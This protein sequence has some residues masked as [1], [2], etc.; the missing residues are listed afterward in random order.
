M[1]PLSRSSPKPKAL[2]KRVELLGWWVNYHRG[3]TY[4]AILKDRIIQLGPQAG[5]PERWLKRIL[6]H[7]ISEFSKKG[8]GP[9]YYGYH[10][11]DHELEAAYFTLIAATGLRPGRVAFTQED[12]NYLFVAALFHD[13]DPQKQ[14]DK[15]HEDSVERIVRNDPKIVQFIEELGLNIDLVIAV[16][17]RTAYPFLGAI[18]EHAE[19][20]MKEL[21]DAAGLAEDDLAARTRFTNLGWFLSVAERIAGYALG[22]FQHSMDLARKNAHAL[23]WHPSVINERSVQ[24]FSSL[25]S[26][27]EMFENVMAGIPEGYRRTFYSNAQ[28]F[29]EAWIEEQELKALL[30]D[31]VKMTAVVE[32]N[33]ISLGPDTDY[34]ADDVRDAVTKIYEGQALPI[35]VSEDDFRRALSEQDTILVTLRMFNDDGSA[36]IVGYAKG[37]PLEKSKLRRG[38]ADENLGKRNTAYL[39][40]IGIM[41]GFWGSSGGHLLRLRFF[42]EASKRG[43]AFVTGYAHRE[44]ILQRAKKGEKMEIVQRYDPDML[45][46][47]RADLADSLYQTILNDSESIYVGQR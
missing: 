31:R 19:S 40:G 32:G 16:I 44:V 38:T 6:R 46:Y 4:E 20:R 8:L 17:H 35:R 5:L 36:R 21:F 28:A 18:A 1:N 41:K 2:F 42:S 25:Q 29:R 23:G 43:Y 33:G 39:E 22:D 27:K 7:A 11:I 14:F 34:I 12:I 15:P 37:Y 26:E 9:D 30:S 13:Y 3:L 24:Y 45:D 10:N 47:Y